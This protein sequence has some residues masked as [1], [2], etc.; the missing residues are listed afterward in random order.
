MTPHR[1]YDV[2]WWF[3]RARSENVLKTSWGRSESTSQGRTLDVRLG[4]SL[5]VI[6]GRPQYVRSRRQKGV[7]SAWASRIFRGRPGEGRPGDQYL[8]AEKSLLR[9]L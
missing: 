3:S 5:D 8:P 2:L 7:P 9:S 4:C 1:P 6:S